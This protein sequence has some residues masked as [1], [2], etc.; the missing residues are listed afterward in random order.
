M[1][2]THG[3]GSAEGV[4]SGWPMGYTFFIAAFMIF[5]GTLLMILAS[6]SSGATSGGLVIF[7]GPIPIALGAGPQS[8]LLITV[9]SALA[10]AMMIL[11]FLLNRRRSI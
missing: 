1:P 5:A 10:I 6:V 2:T 3:V 9:T 4:L 11:F 8:S 7:I